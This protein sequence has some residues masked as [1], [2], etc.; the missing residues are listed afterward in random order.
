MINLQRSMCFFDLETTGTN[1]QQDRIIEICIIKLDP[2]FMSREEKTK[3]INPTI[4]IPKQ[5]SDVHGITDEMVKDAPTFKQIAKGVFDFVDGCDIAGYNSINFDVPLLYNEFSRAGIMWDYSKV[6][7][8]DVCNIFKIKEGRTLSAAVRFYLDKDHE[9]A[10]G[11]TADVEATIK[12]FENQIERY[13]LGDQTI[14][15]LA[16]MSNYDKPIL[17]ISGKFTT[18]SEGDVI[19]NFGQHKGKKAKSERSYLDWMINK[20]DFSQDTKAIALKLI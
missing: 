20:G 3:R 19:F 15:Q 8:I 14:E 2:D 11:A 7:F 13:G 17:D 9:G 10:H 1:T 16:I 6:N 12:V 18:D 5:A 4:P